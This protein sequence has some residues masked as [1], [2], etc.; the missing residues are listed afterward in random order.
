[1]IY[2][3]NKKASV[4]YHRPI[5]TL[6]G[7]ALNDDGVTYTPITGMLIN[8][9]TSEFTLVGGKLVFTNGM[10]KTFLVN[11]TSDLETNK[12]AD[13]T[14]ALVINGTPVASEKTE[15]TFAAASKKGNISITAKAMLNNGDEIEIWAK[16]DGTAGT[17]INIIKL[18]VTLLQV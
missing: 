12:A 17:T 14:Y 4:E 10:A 8:L 18:D 11:G 9:P 6:V 3:S 2:K 1:M 7:L 5:A 15:H 13:I 16:A